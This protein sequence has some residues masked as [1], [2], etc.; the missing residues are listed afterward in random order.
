MGHLVPTGVPNQG[1]SMDFEY[2]GSGEEQKCLMR[3]QCGWKVEIESFRKPWSVTE[4]KVRV[5]KHLED[6]GISQENANS[7]AIYSFD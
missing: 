4:V 7:Q 6:L 1:H 3:C 2:E 5:G